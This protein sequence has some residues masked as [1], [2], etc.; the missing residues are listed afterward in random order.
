MWLPK[1]R[2]TS[3][4]YSNIVGLRRPDLEFRN[5]KAGRILR[6]KIP[7]REKVQRIELDSATILLRHFSCRGKRQDAK[8]SHKI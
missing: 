4:S 2:K 1:G 7:E 8:N 5:K 6:T 3:R